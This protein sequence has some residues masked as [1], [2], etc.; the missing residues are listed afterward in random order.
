[1]FRTVRHWWA[2]GRGR[3]TA[4]LFLFE[5]FVVVIGVLIAQGLANWFAGRS[6][7]AEGERLLEQSMDHARSFQQDLNYWQ[8]FGPC[9]RNH[10]ARI[11]RAAANGEVLSG[12]QIGRP[13]LP[14]PEEME[15]SGDDWRKIRNLIPDSRADA[16]MVLFGTTESYH[17]FIADTARQWATLRLLDGATGPPSAADRS[18][19]RLAATIIDNN[20]RW[21]MF[22]GTTVSVKTLKNAGLPVSAEMPPAARFVDRCGLFKD[23][24]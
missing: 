15:L 14:L 1:M 13:A 2:E 6:E 4:R 20:L 8:R 7:R 24:R 18:Q 19:V 10:V 23:W 16:L 9:V 11:S 12:A 3:N 5:L 22:Q 17:G 21:M